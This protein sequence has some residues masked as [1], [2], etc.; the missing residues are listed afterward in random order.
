M[1]WRN[2]ASSSEER[3]IDDDS[4]HGSRAFRTYAASIFDQI[5]L[6]QSKRHLSE[7]DHR[8]FSYSWKR[9]PTHSLIEPMKS[10]IVDMLEELDYASGG[11]GHKGAKWMDNK[12]QELMDTIRRTLG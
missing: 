9:D 11:Y 6:Y 1:V 10:K 7:E 2:Y 8:K 4:N 12:T 5:V 3:H